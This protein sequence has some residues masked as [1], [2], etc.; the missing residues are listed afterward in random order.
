MVIVLNGRY[1]K[2][3]EKPNRAYPDN[4]LYETEEEM[5][6]LIKR[7]GVVHTFTH[8]IIRIYTNENFPLKIPTKNTKVYFLLFRR[9]VKCFI[10]SITVTY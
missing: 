3:F 7:K 5:Y 1:T 8:K 4:Y 2:N 10:K 6:A 9:F